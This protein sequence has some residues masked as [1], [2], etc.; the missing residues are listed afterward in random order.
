MSKK[1]GELKKLAQELLEA[2]PQEEPPTAEEITAISDWDTLV[3]MRTSTFSNSNPRE[4]IKARMN[5]VLSTISDWDTLRK[6]YEQALS[7]SKSEKMIEARMAEILS[8][9]LPTISDFDQLTEM[10]MQT[11]FNTKSEKLIEV[12]MSRLVESADIANLP[13]WVLQSL[14]NPI[15]V[16]SFLRAPFI[17][18]AKRII[19]TT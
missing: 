1:L 9:L 16:Y 13:D 4:L 7:N 15:R 10:R 17:H 8:D 14:E 5:E 11:L 12:R 6:M 19:A 2:L 18:L 3:K